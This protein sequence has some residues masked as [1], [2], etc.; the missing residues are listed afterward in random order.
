MSPFF[1]N[2]L[3]FAMPTPENC[4]NGSIFQEKFLK[5][6]TFFCQNDPKMGT[7]FEAWA[8]NPSQSNLSYPLGYQKTAWL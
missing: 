6:G 7:G 8:A 4:E 1:Q 3:V 5:M 2:F